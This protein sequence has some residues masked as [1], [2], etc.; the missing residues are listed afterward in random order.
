MSKKSSI[1][2][3]ISTLIFI[4]VIIAILFGL[5]R[6]YKLHYFNDFYK[7]EYNLNT[8]EFIRDR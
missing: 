3:K 4:I 5:H 1:A 8:T 7:A 6:A 2:S